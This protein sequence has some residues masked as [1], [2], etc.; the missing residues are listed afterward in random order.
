MEV[1]SVMVVVRTHALVWLAGEPE[2]VLSLYSTT[3]SASY[4]LEKYGRE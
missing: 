3:K 4:R 1:P 2:T